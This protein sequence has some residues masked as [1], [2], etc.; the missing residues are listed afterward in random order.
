MVCNDGP[1]IGIICYLGHL[2][3]SLFNEATHCKTFY[4][5]I[6][7]IHTMEFYVK[8]GHLHPTTLFASFNID[9]LCI[10]FSHQ[11]V[12]I[13]LEHFLNDYVPDRLIDGMTIDTIIQLVRLVL[14]NQFF[15]HH[16]KLYRQIAGSA[17]GSSLTI[18]LVYIYLFYWQPNLLN[19]FINENEVF[20]R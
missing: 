9:E 8:S 4:K 15:I 19:I 11:Q 3:G 7:V 18:P 14:E 6:D 20:G 17:S 2:L 13:A 12:I 5:A 10:T 1:T 16:Y